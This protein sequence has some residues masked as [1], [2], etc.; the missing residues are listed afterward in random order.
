[1]R[2]SRIESDPFEDS[3]ALDEVGL[4]CSLAQPVDGDNF[5]FLGAVGSHS[6]EVVSFRLFEF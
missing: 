4:R 5:V 3:T 1:M 6:Q 2:F